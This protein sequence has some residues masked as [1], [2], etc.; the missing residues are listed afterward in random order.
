M[1]GE[2]LQEATENRLSHNTYVPI[3]ASVACVIAVLSLHI[4]MN[5]QF[6]GLG[7]KIDTKFNVLNQKILEIEKTQSDRGFEIRQKLADLDRQFHHRWSS[8]DMQ[9]WAIKFRELNPES[10]IPPV[11]HTSP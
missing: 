5:D 2:L 3:G 8:L 1:A 4:W 9:E 7:E 10:K 6:S 11:I